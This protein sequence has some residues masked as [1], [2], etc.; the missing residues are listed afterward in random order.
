MQR[1]ISSLA[2]CVS[3]VALL[4]AAA[5]AHAG[6]ATFVSANGSDGVGCGVTPAS[7]CRQIFG[8]G[9]ALAQ[10]DEGGIIHVL[11]GEYIAFVVDKGIDI[12]ADAGQA[13]I[14]STVAFGDGGIVVGVSG[15]QVVRIRGFLISAAHGIVVNNSGVVHIEDCTLLGA[16]SRYGIVYS[17]TG[18]GEL[19]VSGTM[20][21]RPAVPATGGGGILIKPVGRSCSHTGRHHDG[22]QGGE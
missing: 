7:A 17:P 10:T 2:V 12:V 19:Y 3:L 11:L 9:G 16:E 1:L 18:A 13:S 5:P 20:L 21:A 4:G 8:A 15:N 6:F 22:W 14:F